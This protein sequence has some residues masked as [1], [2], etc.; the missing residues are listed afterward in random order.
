MGKT[1][2]TPHP[3]QHVVAQLQTTCGSIDPK[4]QHKLGTGRDFDHKMVYGIVVVVVGDSKS[5]RTH[6]HVALSEC[7]RDTTREGAC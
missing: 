3:Y 7:S 1:D 6:G 4:T 5:P 2:L